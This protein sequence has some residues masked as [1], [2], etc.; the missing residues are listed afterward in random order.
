MVFEQ[1]CVKEGL[2]FSIM[3]MRKNVHKFATYPWSFPGEA[4]W[5][6]FPFLN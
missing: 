1:S 4:D 5:E 3:G 6:L 2:D